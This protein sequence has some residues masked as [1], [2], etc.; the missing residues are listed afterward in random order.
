M[1]WFGNRE[2]SK[3]RKFESFVHD[4]TQKEETAARSA[5]DEFRKDLIGK[6]LTSKLLLKEHLFLADELGNEDLAA[7]VRAFTLKAQWR[8]RGILPANADVELQELKDRQWL[9]GTKADVI[10]EIG[11]LKAIAILKSALKDTKPNNITA[12]NTSLSEALITDRLQGRFA[13]EIDQLNLAGL[14]IELTQ[15]DSKHGA[16]RFKISLIQSSSRNAGDVLSEGEYRC[17]A[18]AGFMA[19]LATNN[20]HSGIIFDDL[21]SSLLKQSRYEG[22]CEAFCHPTRRCGNDAKALRAAL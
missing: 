10:A 13:Q 4:R 2:V 3:G 12:K 19:E 16:S 17:V 15:A 21:V 11:R 20:S 7:A 8:L 22:V 9:A 14:A 5:L 6:A 1:T 18:L